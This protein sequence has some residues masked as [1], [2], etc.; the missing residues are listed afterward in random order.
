MPKKYRVEITRH[1]EQDIE[2]VWQ[3]IVEDSPDQAEKFI[4]SL[5]E[6][7]KTLESFPLRCPIIPES[8][9]LGFEYRH[10]L[11]GDYRIIYRVIGSVVYVLRVIH[12]ARLLDLSILK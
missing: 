2:T 1:A 7:T 6:H 3:H 10:L 9:Y 5:E 11:Y 4:S 12:S 8:E